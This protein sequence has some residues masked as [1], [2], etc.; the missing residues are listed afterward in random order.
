MS[1]TITVRD[2]ASRVGGEV[3]GNADL[4]LSGIASLG[5]A[6]P[7][8]LVYVDSPKYAGALSSTRAGAAILPGGVDPPP[9]MTAVRVRQPAL[10]IAQALEIL[11][12]VERAFD[13]VSPHAAVGKSVEMA[14]GVAIGPH[15]YV[16]DHV[17]IGRG[18]EIHPNATIGRGSAIGEDCVIHAGVHIYDGVTVGNRVIIHA[19]A[20]IGAD[21]FGY[22]QEDVSTS[23]A[24]PDE[25]IRHRKVRQ[26]GRVVIEDDVEIGANTT[27]DRAALDVTRIGRGS[28]IDNLVQI[29]HNCVLGRHCIIVGQ[30]GLS[31][32]CV[33]GDYATIAGQAGLAGHLTVGARAVV[34]AQAFIGAGVMLGADVRIGTQASV[35][36]ALIGDRVVLYPGARVG[37]D[38]FGFAMTPSGFVSVPQIGRV[39][40]ED[41]VEIGANTTIDRG[42]ANDTVIGMGSRLDN[43][44]QIGH[45]VRIGRFCVIVAQ[46]GISG[47]TVLED[48]V[49][50]AGQAGLVG[51]LRIGAK[52][53][54]G[55][56]AGVSHDVPAGAEVVG[57]PAQPF[58][59]FA[60]DRI[61]LARLL[62]QAGAVKSTGDA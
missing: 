47:S 13:G 30:A 5:S 7:G 1:R 35:S 6:G 9:G 34:G 56:Q 57:S 8:D 39:I 52:A 11:C 53:R 41:D 54:I 51:H 46:V 48:F 16:G 3:T 4:V 19:G 37:Q 49:V 18:T 12:P 61:R 27:I 50:V 33:L 58:K 20:V 29:G 59:E 38:G 60:R 25:P 21:G 36:H 31:G 45:N 32:S 44:V 23:G 22:I 10:A 55:P 24:P 28:K 17:R 40:I 26:I 43:L 62:R 2:L 42:S 15:A 14:E